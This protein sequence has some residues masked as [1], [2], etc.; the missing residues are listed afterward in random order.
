LDDPVHGFSN[1]TTLQLLDH[2]DTTYGVKSPDDLSANEDTMALPWD[3]SQPIETL[4]RRFN[5]CTQFDPDMPPTKAVRVAAT[6]IEQSELFP[7]DI[8]DWKRRPLADQ[9]MENLRV[10]FNRAN[11]ERLRQATTANAGYHAAANRATAEPPPNPPNLGGRAPADVA[12]ALDQGQLDY[13]WTHGASRGRNH[14]SATCNRPAHNHNSAATLFN[15][16]GG[17]PTIQSRVP[18]IHVP[19]QHNH[20]QGQGHRQ[21]GGG[22]RPNAGAAAHGGA[23]NG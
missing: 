20:Q 7:E 23:P 3:T 4:W 9:T 10:A 15:L 12:R 22:A 13:C 19:P 21:N 5:L 2:L 6:V 17:N 14:N 1:A 18:R 11:R 16:M 8:R